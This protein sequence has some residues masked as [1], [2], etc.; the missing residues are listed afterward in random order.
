MPNTTIPNEFKISRITQ[1][2]V[3]NRLRSMGDPCAVAALVVKKSLAACLREFDAND[4]RIADVVR[5]VCRGG[6]AGLLIA[7]QSLSRGA[8]KIIAVVIEL[9]AE[10]RLDTTLAM[11]GALEGVADLH[12]SVSSERM[13]EILL[14]IGVHF[15]GAGKV[16]SAIVD[17]RQPRRVRKARR[18]AGPA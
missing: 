16:L 2:M 10:L 11:H 17:T 5:E 12:N 6:M 1:E 13:D 7:E 15:L 3:I 14:N 9:A 18:D 4:A 8:V